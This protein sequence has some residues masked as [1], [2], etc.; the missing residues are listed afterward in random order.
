MFFLFNRQLG[1]LFHSLLRLLYQVQQTGHFIR[2]LGLDQLLK[3]F[4]AQTLFKVGGHI[5]LLPPAVEHFETG[6]FFV[7]TGAA[8]SKRNN[9]TQSRAASFKLVMHHY[10]APQI[11]SS[12]AR[13]W[14]QIKSNRENTTAFNYIHLLLIFSGLG[15]S[16][17]TCIDLAISSSLSS[18]SFNAP[19][20]YFS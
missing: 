5:K 20:R 13:A 3:C 18:K 4:G 7:A 12:H 17:Y 15:K 16:A 6:M 2:R 14:E 1:L 11:K 8:V 10:G 9:T 19:E